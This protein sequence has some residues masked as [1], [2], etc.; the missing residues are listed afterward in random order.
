MK[1]IIYI[2][3]GMLAW[4][5]CEDENSLIGPEGVFSEYTDSRDGKIYRCVTIGDQ[6]W[7]A[8]NLAYRLP[9]GS[10]D[11]CYTYREENLDTN[12]IEPA[13]ALFDEVVQNAINDGKI[14]SDPLPEVP[15][16]SP[17][18]FVMMY[19]DYPGS[20]VSIVNLIANTVTWYPSMQSTVE[21]LNQIL[22]ETKTKTIGLTAEEYFLNAEEEND[23]YA[24]KYGLLYTYDA[25]LKA[26]PDG[27]RLPTDEDWKK[28]EQTLGMSTSESN[29][30]GWRGSLEGELM[31]Q[32]DGINLRLCGFIA[33]GGSGSYLFLRNAGDYGF[34]WTSTVDESYKK[35]TAVYFRRIRY[36]SSQIERDVTTIADES[37]MGMNNKYMG[38]RYVRDAK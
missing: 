23:G 18:S 13:R 8:E 28:L 36:N 6:T 32:K 1:K 38:V 25:A 19:L 14:S 17:A 33:L 29:A 3:F 24:E 30:I 35:S 9:L 4:W 15:F 20:A 2:L 10:V 12:R 11:G 34:Y 16:F 37:L 22:A 31:Q 27:W 21:T 26:L 5:S 7:M